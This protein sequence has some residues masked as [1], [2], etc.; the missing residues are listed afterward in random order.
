MG[1]SLNGFLSGALQDPRLELRDV[2]GGNLIASNDNW[3]STIGGGVITS[4]QAIEIEATG[5]APGND[6]E[7]AILATLNPGSYTAVIAG[8]N[9]L[10]GIAV[11]EV[12]DLD[13]T[14]PSTLANIS[15]RGFVE[16]GDKV[17][18]G[19]FIYLGGAGQTNVV[20]RAI[21]PSLGAFGIANPLNDPVLEL[22]N[23]NGTMMATND[24]W[25]TS[26]D[27]AT[28]QRLGFGLSNDAEAAI[29]QIA[30]PR[31][32]YTAIVKDKNG[33]SGVGVVEAYIF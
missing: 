32:S 25:K 20:V 12:Y 28:L 30:L 9:N 23:K 14:Y 33:G 5:I 17:M 7:S 8:S 29:M 6:A 13:A 27:A 31:D 18:I 22:R 26:P 3:R 19:G 10:T 2:P 21:G 16:G 15:T 24:D 11:V 1:P 4:N